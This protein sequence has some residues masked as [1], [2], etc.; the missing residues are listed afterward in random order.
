[1]GVITAVAFVVALFGLRRGVQQELPSDKRE[2][3]AAQA[4]GEG[5]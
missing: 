5:D 2:L 1:M 3:R 4:P